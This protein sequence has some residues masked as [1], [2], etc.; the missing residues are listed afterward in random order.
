MQ[1]M[2]FV[3]PHLIFSKNR[4]ALINFPENIE[5]KFVPIS[6]Y[7][8]VQPKSCIEIEHFSLIEDVAMQIEN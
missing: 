7:L 2:F 5:I 3:L 1:I 8:K 6:E 4:I